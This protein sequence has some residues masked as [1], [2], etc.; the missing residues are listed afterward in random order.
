MH[1][2]YLKLSHSVPML[3]SRSQFLPPYQHNVFHFPANLIWCA[4]L[5]QWPCIYTYAY[6]CLLHSC[7]AISSSLL[8]IALRS[9][10][11]L[12]RNMEVYSQLRFASLIARSKHRPRAPGTHVDSQSLPKNQDDVKEIARRTGGWCGA[13]YTWSVCTLT[14]GVQ[15]LDVHSVE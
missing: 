5:L 15:E 12:P 8:L 10:S 1:N 4:P 3:A 11:S 2:D 7:I 6:R 9:F 14:T 13:R